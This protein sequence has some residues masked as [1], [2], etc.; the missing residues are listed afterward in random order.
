VRKP[1][2]N[3]LPGQGEGIHELL[4]WQFDARKFHATHCP[5][6]LNSDGM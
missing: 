5:L 3:P 4:A 6:P 2:P 1:T